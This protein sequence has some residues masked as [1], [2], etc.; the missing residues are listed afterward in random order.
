MRGGPPRK[1]S[2]REIGL[3][4]APYLLLV[5]FVLLWGV[6][7][8]T[9]ALVDGVDTLSRLI[10][11]SLNRNAERFERVANELLPSV[12]VIVPAHNEAA[13]ID[14]CLTSVNCCFC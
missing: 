14:R 2:G 11:V 13:L 1:H 9:P 10:R 4:W 8:L 3:A 7:L 12:A 6:W 5:T